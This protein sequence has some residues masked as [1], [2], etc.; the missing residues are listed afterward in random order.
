MGVF[1]HFAARIG[2]GL[3]TVCFCLRDCVGERFQLPLVQV[4]LDHRE[5]LALFEA[6]MRD[7]PR[8]QIM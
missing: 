7:K 8:A 4:G 1:T 2:A 6:N 5:E 3:L